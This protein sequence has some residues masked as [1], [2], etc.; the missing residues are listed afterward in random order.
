MTAETFNVVPLY[1]RKAKPM[2]NIGI[3]GTKILGIAACHIKPNTSSNNTNKTTGKYLEIFLLTKNFFMV[4]KSRSGTN[5]NK[6]AKLAKKDRI[7]F[8]LKENCEISEKYE[9]ETVLRLIN[10]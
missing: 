1:N 3:I 6:K 5:P 10:R 9:L 4:D 8:K 7:N 2:D